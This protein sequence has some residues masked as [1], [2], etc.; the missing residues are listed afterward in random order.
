MVSEKARAMLL[1]AALHWKD[2]VSS[3]LLPMAVQYEAYQYNH[4]PNTPADLFTGSTFPCHKLLQMHTWECPVYV[5]DP[6]LQQAKKFQHWDPCA[7]QVMFCLYSTFKED[8]SH[9][10]SMLFLM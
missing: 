4:L 5:L 2:G 10:N 6:K 8:T 1:H 3:F 7:C 9:H